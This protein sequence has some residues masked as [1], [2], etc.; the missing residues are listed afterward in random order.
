MNFGR[1]FVIGAD[2]AANFQGVSKEIKEICL[3]LLENFV[4]TYLCMNYRT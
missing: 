3:A 2:P 4:Y 1:L